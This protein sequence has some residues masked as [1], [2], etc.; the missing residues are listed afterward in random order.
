MHKNI[1]VSH[2]PMVTVTFLAG[3]ARVG[4]R[5]RYTDGG[6][7]RRQRVEELALYVQ[8]QGIY[9]DFG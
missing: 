7:I 6:A 4:L 8:S 1:Y 2:Y 9:R 5:D 3:E